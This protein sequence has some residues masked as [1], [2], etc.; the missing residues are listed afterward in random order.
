MIFPYNIAE[1]EVIEAA[2]KVIIVG[3]IKTIDAESSIFL[4]ELNVRVKIKTTK[5]YFISM[6]NFAI[7]L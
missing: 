4:Q 1:E 5:I 6:C 2:G 7:M 3:L